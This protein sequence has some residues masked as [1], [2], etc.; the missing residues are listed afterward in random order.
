LDKLLV[1]DRAAIPPSSLNLFR[2]ERMKVAAPWD[3]FLPYAPRTPVG[4]AHEFV[5][6]TGEA[7][8]DAEDEGF[9]P[10]ATI[11]PVF[12]VDAARILNEQTPLSLLLDAAGRETLPG[13]ARR[14]IAIAGWVRAV[15]L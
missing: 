2:A 14:E 1:A 5:Q 4:T 10:P 13:P 11:R 7:R 6:Y 3:E 8:P 9:P 12:D 15:L